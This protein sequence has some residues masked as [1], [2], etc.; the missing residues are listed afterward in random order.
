MPLVLFENITLEILG[1]PFSR[2]DDVTQS[3]FEDVL[4]IGDLKSYLFQ[5]AI[6]N[7]LHSSK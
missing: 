4:P 7:S 1:R 5:V 6:L 3:P 2:I